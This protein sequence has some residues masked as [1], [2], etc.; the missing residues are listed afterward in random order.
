MTNVLI[1]MAISFGVIVAVDMV[2][3]PMIEAL[4][5]GPG[6]PGCSNT[7]GLNASKGRCFH[8]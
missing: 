1:I 4:A 8:P 5:A 7:P 2:V 6:N 3:L